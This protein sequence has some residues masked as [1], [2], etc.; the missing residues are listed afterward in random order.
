MSYIDI[1]FHHKLIILSC[2]IWLYNSL[3]VQAKHYF[4]SIYERNLFC[5]KDKNNYIFK[6]EKGRREAKRE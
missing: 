3:V 6:A 1:L 4:R 5:V 2:L